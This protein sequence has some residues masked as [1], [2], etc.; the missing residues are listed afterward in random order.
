MQNRPRIRHIPAL[1]GLRAIAVVAVL[2]FHLGFTWMRGGFLGVDVFFVVSGY[3]ITSLLLTEWNASRRVNLGQFWARRARRLLPALYLVLAATLAY[4]LVVLP[5]EV[6]SLRS[7][8]LAALGYVTNWYLVVE[9]RPYFETLGRPPLLQHLWSLA[10]EEQ[11]YLVWPLL[12]L[13]AMRFIGRRG[14]IALVVAGGF[15]SSVLMALLYTP[16]GAETRVYYG[17]DTRAVALLAGAALA[18]AWARPAAASCSR[19]TAISVDASAAAALGALLAIFV[20]VDEHTLLLYRGGFAAVALLSAV[21]IFGAAHPSSKVVARVLGGRI[22]GWIGQRS[23]G[24]Y[25]WHWPIFM[26]TRP[27]DVGFS[28]PLLITLQLGLT[29]LLAAL[30]YRFVEAPLRAVGP[31]TLF[32]RAVRSQGWS[33]AAAVAGWSGAA[34]A[35]I[36][37]VSAVSVAQSETPP[38]WLPQGALHTIVSAAPGRFQQDADDQLCLVDSSAPSP[39]SAS[40]AFTV[41][42]EPTAT[43]P[44]SPPAA[45]VTPVPTEAAVTVPTPPPPPPPA[46]PVKADILAIG[47]S[48]LLGAAPYLGPALGSVEVDAA[49]GRQAYTVVAMLAARRES[50]TLPAT[51]IVAIGNNGTFTSGQFDQ[52]MAALAGV[53]RVI[54]VNLHVARPWEEGNNAVITTGVAA[55]PNAVL[56]DWHSASAGQDGYFWDDGIHLRPEGAEVYASLIA[57]KAGR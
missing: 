53:P 7:S 20:L 16:G 48:V 31:V 41:T 43:P 8:A 25:L 51:V 12:F 45:P 22:P 56:V 9:H 19:R 52:M 37:L 32:R 15:A 26:V 38:P 11:F 29:F 33:S 36:V 39:L 21:L 23:Y 3:L 6:V 14:L 40:V 57:A 49:V 47:D 34:G 44:A 2:F 35:L 28:G 50:G 10:V 46:P 4:A 17:T 13:P 1:D 42:P 18:L 27:E 55:H 5:G 54:F 24:I 30:S